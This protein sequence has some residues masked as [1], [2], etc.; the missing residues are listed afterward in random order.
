[1]KKMI[2]RVITDLEIYSQAWDISKGQKH[3]LACLAKDLTKVLAEMEKNH[4]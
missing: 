2:E 1:M 4:E 3:S